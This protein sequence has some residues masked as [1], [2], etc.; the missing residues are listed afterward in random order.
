MVSNYPRM[1]ESYGAHESS[2]CPRDPGDLNLK[3]QPNACVRYGKGRLP[4]PVP[5]QR[6]TPPHLLL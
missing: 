6:T 3:S 4:H 2:L 1:E 5:S